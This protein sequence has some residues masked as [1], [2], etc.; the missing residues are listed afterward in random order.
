VLEAFISSKEIGAR[1]RLKD[2]FL[3][4]ENTAESVVSS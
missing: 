1:K 2:W 4:K 3:S